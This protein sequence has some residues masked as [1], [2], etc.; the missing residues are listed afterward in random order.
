MHLTTTTARGSKVDDFWFVA[1]FFCPIYF[2]FHLLTLKTQL[3]NGGNFMEFL[4]NQ[5]SN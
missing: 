4:I 1:S 2:E 3:Q 5:S